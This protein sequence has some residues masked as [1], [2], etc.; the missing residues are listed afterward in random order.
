MASRQH[1]AIQ[2][3]D[4]HQR[5]LQ[6]TP[7]LPMQKKPKPP[8]QTVDQSVLDLLDDTQ[9]VGGVSV[10]WAVMANHFLRGCQPRRTPSE[11]GVA[12]ASPGRITAALQQQQPQKPPSLPGSSAKSSGTQAPGGSGSGSRSGA[13]TA[14]AAAATVLR[15]NPGPGSS[16]RT[17]TPPPLS[18]PPWKLETGE[19]RG[20][21][22]VFRELRIH[23][24]VDDTAFQARSRSS[25]SLAIAHQQ[26]AMTMT[27][28]H[29]WFNTG[30]L[31]AGL[32][33]R[34]RIG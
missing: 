31:P 3:F 12:D 10:R 28:A 13:A 15:P 21:V 8:R 20:I 34:G 9:C 2:K 32:M 4:R 16:A 18:S 22:S 27:I 7:S 33:P 6:Q 14:A 29:H 19:G 26:L 17:L 30:P 24:L 5:Q 23:E 1:S 11:K 25:R